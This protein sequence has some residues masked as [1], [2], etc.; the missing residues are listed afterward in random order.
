[1]GL[2]DKLKD[3]ANRVTGGAAH[4]SIEYEPCVAQHE[5][6]IR[7]RIEVTGN[8]PDSGFMAFRVGTNG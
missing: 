1:M 3:V 5:W 2:F 6:S 8:D 4:V 7:G